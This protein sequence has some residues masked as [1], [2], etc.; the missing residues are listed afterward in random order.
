MEDYEVLE[1]GQ[2]T[3]YIIESGPL[4]VNMVLLADRSTNVAAVIDPAGNVDLIHKIL[5]EH[6][7]RLQSILFT[8][9]HFDHCMMVDKMMELAREYTIK[10]F[11]ALHESELPYYENVTKHA[12]QYGVHLRNPEAKINHLLEDGEDLDVGNE[13]IRVIH[14]PGHSPGSVSFYYPDGNILIS[15]DTLFHS[16]VGR[17]DLQGGNMVHLVNSVEKKLFTLPGE[18]TVIPGHGEFT[19]IDYEIENNYVLKSMKKAI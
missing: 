16:S 6:E 7:Y 17:V 19:R 14:T 15:G 13:V 10:P 4:G 2:L 5:R 8:H 3:I 18:T 1:A 11:L 12:I 9:A